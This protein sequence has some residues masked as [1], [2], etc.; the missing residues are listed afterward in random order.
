MDIHPTEKDLQNV[1]VAGEV[2]NNQ[3]SHL[4]CEK[5]EENENKCVYG[6][7][8]YCKICITNQYLIL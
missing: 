4:V 1:S 5:G 8:A 3:V 7:P 2:Y 6:C